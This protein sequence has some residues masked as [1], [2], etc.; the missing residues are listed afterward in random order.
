[1]E[2]NGSGAEPHHVYGNG[3]TFVR[4]CYIL[5]QHWNILYKISKMNRDRGNSYWKFNEGWKFFKQANRHI[6]MLKELDAQF[7]AS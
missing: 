1:M 5:L 2:Y 3:N 6:K 7:P 4:A